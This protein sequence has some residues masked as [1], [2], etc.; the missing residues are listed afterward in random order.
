MALSTLSSE[1]GLLAR[2]P[3]P[4]A[5]SP[6]LLILPALLLLLLLGWVVGGVVVG[7][8]RAGMRAGWGVV[9]LVPLGVVGVRVGGRVWVG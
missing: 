7:L 6:P 9:R 8:D 2:P 1:I 5:S 4:W 3:W